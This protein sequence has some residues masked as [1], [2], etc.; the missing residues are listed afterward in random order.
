V[1]DKNPINVE[2]DGEKY[3]VVKIASN[4][5]QPESYED[6]T[7]TIN[8]MEVP[9]FYSDVT[10]FTLV[11]LK[12]SQGQ[13]SLF[14][15]DNEKY[16]KYIELKFGN[17]TI[18][19]LELTKSVE[20]FTEAKVTIQNNE[21][22]GLKNDKNSRYYLVQGFNVETGEEGL[23]LYD[24]KDQSLVIYDTESFN[25]LTKQFKLLM[26][27]LLVF[28]VTTFGFFIIIL[29]MLHK[30]S[31]L[32]KIIRNNKK[33]SQKKSEKPEKTTKNVETDEK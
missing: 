5:K 9:A 23:Y 10:K 15:Y 16:E 28:G 27:V 7:I 30:N 32:K 22:N 33:S 12:D 26:I 17:L 4:L 1:L 20:N 13:I 11:G 3:T 21:L 25:G 18:Y 8:N 29:C 31:K 6:K 2:V 19:P 24:E 14:K